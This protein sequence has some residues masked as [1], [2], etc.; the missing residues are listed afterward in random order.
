MSSLSQIIILQLETNLGLLAAPSSPDFAM[1]WSQAKIRSAG[2]RLN[3]SVYTVTA[4]GCTS[5]LSCEGRAT[6]VDLKPH[7]SL[8]PRS[9]GEMSFSKDVIRAADSSKARKHN[10]ASSDSDLRCGRPELD[11]SAEIH[12]RSNFF[13]KRDKFG[14]RD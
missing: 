11:A 10:L 13:R 8:Y 12:L 9:N 5:E 6:F 1:R 14:K 4:R 2:A 7:L 3:S